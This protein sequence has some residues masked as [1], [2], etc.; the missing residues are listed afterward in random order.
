MR[1]GKEGM[2]INFISHNRKVI[3]TQ[4][5]G[6]LLRLWIEAHPG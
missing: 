2:N 3:G 6:H 4:R 1:Q 5:R